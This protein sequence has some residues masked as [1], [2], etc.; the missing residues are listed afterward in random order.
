MIYTL[1]LL[2]MVVVVKVD[3]DMTIIRGKRGGQSKMQVGGEFE[4]TLV[5]NI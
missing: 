1:V 4:K 3:V 5:F 2:V